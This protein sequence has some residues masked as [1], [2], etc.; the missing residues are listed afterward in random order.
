M[1]VG[2]SSH[3]SCCDACSESAA[4]LAV[5]SLSC[6]STIQ[7]GQLLVLPLRPGLQ[8]HPSSSIPFRG[9]W[10]SPA[11]Q[12]ACGLF[13]TSEQAP[14]GAYAWHKSNHLMSFSS[15]CSRLRIGA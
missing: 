12:F 13:G 10:A 5:A 8:G 7:A 14:G 6:S 2:C 15:I 9:T 3:R 1:L 11:V 4:A